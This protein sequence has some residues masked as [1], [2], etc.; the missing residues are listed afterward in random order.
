MVHV[1]DSMEYCQKN[2]EYGL[3]KKADTG[4]LK[5]LPGVDMDFDIPTNADLNFTPENK[6][7]NIKQLLDFLSNNKIY[8]AE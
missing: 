3:Y 7:D 5:Y 6:E 8:P 1:N 2:D 4:E